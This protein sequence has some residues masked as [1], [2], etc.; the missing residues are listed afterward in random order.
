MPTGLA[1]A[2]KLTPAIF[3]LYLLLAGKR[4]AFLVATLSAAAATLV[5]AAIVPRASLDFWGRLAHGD[6]DSAEASSTTRTSR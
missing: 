6:T 2:I 3:L 4:R 1:A 5:S